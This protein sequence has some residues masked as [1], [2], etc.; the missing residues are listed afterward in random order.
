MLQNVI[1]F[2]LIIVTIKNSSSS[3]ISSHQLSTENE[4]DNDRYKKLQNQI[5]QIQNEQIHDRFIFSKLLHNI[6]DRQDDII[7][8]Q[9]I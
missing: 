8:Q 2:I 5:E 1:I 3:I 4:D 9:Q 6:I 7:K